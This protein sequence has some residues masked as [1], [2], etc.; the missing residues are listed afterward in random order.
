MSII[1]HV[2]LQKNCCSWLS[3][4]PSYV[5]VMKCVVMTKISYIAGVKSD[6]KSRQIKLN[7]ENE[8]LMVKARGRVTGYRSINTNFHIY[9]PKWPNLEAEVKNWITN[10]TT[11]WISVSTRSSFFKWEDGRSHSITNFVGKTSCCYRFIKKHELWNMRQSWSLSRNVGSVIP[12]MI[13]K[14]MYCLK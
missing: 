14:M 9:A 5:L 13:L 1:K 12:L 10:L 4:R 2:T 6:S 7:W 11:N 3:V 8:K